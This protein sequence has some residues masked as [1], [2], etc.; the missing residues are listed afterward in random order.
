[1]SE[2]G[3]LTYDEAAKFLNI[4]KTTLQSLVCRKQ[5]PHIRLGPRF[6]RFSI[7]ALRAWL[8]ERAV[9]PRS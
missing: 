3:N 5:I 6:V 7:D 8:N 1:M 2:S 9:A 4:K